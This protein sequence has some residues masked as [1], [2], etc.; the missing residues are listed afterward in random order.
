MRGLPLRR[1]TAADRPP[2]RQPEISVNAARLDRSAGP[3][4]GDH[5]RLAG[6]RLAAITAEQ[7]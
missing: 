2:V 7:D 1:E 6:L 4:T 5:V 3:A